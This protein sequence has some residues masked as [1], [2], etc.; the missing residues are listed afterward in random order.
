[1]D[2]FGRL[3]PADWARG[4]GHGKPEFHRPPPNAW[5]RRPLGS[6][7][8]RCRPEAPR[9]VRRHRR[10]ADYPIAAR[11]RCRIAPAKAASP[12]LCRKRPA[13]ELAETSSGGKVE[14]AAVVLQTR[15]PRKQTGGVFQLLSFVN[16][17]RRD[18][19]LTALLANPL[20]H[21]PVKVVDLD[22]QFPPH[23]VEQHLGDCI[24]NFNGCVGQSG[25]TILP[26]V[27]GLEDFIKDA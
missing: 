1:M 23:I 11:C 14:I 10:F 15:G 8:H 4:S 25:E 6:R 17:P 3:L 5:R 22:C 19:T 7:G 21:E 12:G 26:E 16:R 20:Q 27:G 18:E 13:E 2:W 9:H 24:S